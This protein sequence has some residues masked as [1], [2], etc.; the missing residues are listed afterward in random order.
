MIT[1]AILGDRSFA[2]PLWQRM[3]TA[4][5]PYSV[6]TWSQRLWPTAPEAGGFPVHGNLR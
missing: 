2:G 3:L 4:L 6:A 5:L 1:D